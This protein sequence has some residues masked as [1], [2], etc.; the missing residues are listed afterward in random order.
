MEHSQDWKGKHNLSRSQVVD[1]RLSVRYT[2]KTGLDCCT[3]KVQ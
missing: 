3:G 2:E 1:G